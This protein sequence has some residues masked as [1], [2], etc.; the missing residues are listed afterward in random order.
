LIG[1]AIRVHGASFG[2]HYE[3]VEDTLADL[4]RVRIVITGRS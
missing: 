2:W 3:V 4:P 1:Q